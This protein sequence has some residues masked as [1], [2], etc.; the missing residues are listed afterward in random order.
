VLDRFGA[1][2]AERVISDRVAEQVA[3]QKATARSRT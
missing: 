2:Y 3:D 1:S